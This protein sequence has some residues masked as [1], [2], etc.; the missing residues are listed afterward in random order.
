MLNESLLVRNCHALQIVSRLN[1]GN[2]GKITLHNIF[3]QIEDTIVSEVSRLT[4]LLRNWS[5]IFFAIRLSHLFFL[6]P[7]DRYET[8]LLVHGTSSPENL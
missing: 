5:L 6:V 1:E 7:I 8:S 3:P 2:E 4:L